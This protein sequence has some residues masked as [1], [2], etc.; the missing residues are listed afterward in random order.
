MATTLR[1][2]PLYE[3]H[4]AAGAKMV[5]F[6][7]W[8]MPVQYTGVAAEH[9]AV[10]E[11]CGVFDVSHMGEIE[12]SGPQALEL[13]QRLLSNDVAQIAVEVDGGGA[14]Y[15]VLCNEDGGVIDDLFTYRLDTDRY[16]TVTNAANHARDLDWFQRHASDFPEAQV[17][18][19]IDDYAMIAVQGPRARGIVQAISDAPL[20]AR[21]TAATRRLGGGEV[22]VC[23]TGYTGE[24][25]VELLCPPDA[26]PRLWDELVRRGA[27][28][29]GLAARDTLRLE[30][31]FHLYGNDLMLERGPIEAGLGW[32]CRE[33]TG[34]VGADA[35]RA[36]REAGP[37]E[38]LVAFEIDGPGIARQGNA[39]VGGGEVT[40]GTMSPSLGRAIGM[41]YVPA[42]RSA[43]GAALEID[44]R[45]K[46]R[47]AV[48]KQK[49]LYRKG[50]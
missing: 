50:S 22:L 45:G 20:P 12:V 49:P 26:A 1:R 24:E 13:L 27:T 8:E 5:E 34:F 3:Q 15:S 9:R 40:S 21:M 17:A 47:R 35:V 43:P 37:R 18:D 6:A 19:R 16:L 11:S 23:G 14:Q 42:E 33:D 30:V 36:V 10:R 32:C 38:K 29:V 48:V 7:G 2:T 44:V 4:V 28:Q 39:I 31:C 46:M 41:A 25:G